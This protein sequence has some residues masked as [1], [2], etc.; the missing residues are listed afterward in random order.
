MPA[1]NLSDRRL[2]SVYIVKC[3]NGSLYTGIAADL[4]A[5]LAEHNA[6]TG[7]KYTRS[8][9][10]VKLLW[11]ARKRGRSSASKLEARIK[12]LT[13]EAKHELI[14]GKLRF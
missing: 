13:R 11:S 3:A 2:W 8:F 6:G 7:A 5:R 4:P 12:S 14:A 1:K 9:G 10:P